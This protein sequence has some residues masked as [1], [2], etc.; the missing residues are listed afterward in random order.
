VSCVRG[1]Q[2]KKLNVFPE[3]GLVSLAVKMGISSQKL[4]HHGILLAIATCLYKDH[5][6]HGIFRAG[7]ILERNR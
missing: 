7:V 3:E 1:A 6:P 5:L 4:R 2:T